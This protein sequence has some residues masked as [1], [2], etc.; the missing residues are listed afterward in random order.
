M[1]TIQV[2]GRVNQR[3]G[4][5]ILDYVRFYPSVLQNSIRDFDIVHAN[6]GL[7]GPF[8]LTQPRRPV[9]LSLWGSDLM[10]KY[11]RVSKTCA[12]YCDQVILPTETMAPYLDTEYEII[13]F[14]VN[15]ELFRPLPKSYARN[16]LGWDTNKKIIFFPYST[17]RPVKNY[18]LAKQI[19]DNIAVDVTLKSGGGIPHEEMPLYM[20]AS[21]V[22]LITSKRE[23]GPLTVK[24][25]ALC[26]V[27][28]ISTDVGF[29]SDILSNV[30]NTF[31]CQNEQNLTQA[32]E[33]L[34]RS[35]C[36]SN[37]RKKLRNEV[38]LNTMGD[39]ILSVYKRLLR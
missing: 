7:T 38:G 2:P 4:R 25:A 39:R 13:P 32:V 33:S 15:A 30:S 21:D 36:Q 14:G 17:E 1:T 8:A 22:V 26:N 19:V 18:S 10:G 5:S 11:G 29:V 16:K 12:K 27:P 24:E 28:I 37:G 23:S 20:N 3:E 9:V 31:V 35:P 6:F 34:I